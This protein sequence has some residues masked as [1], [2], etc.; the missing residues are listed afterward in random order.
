MDWEEASRGVTTLRLAEIIGAAARMAPSYEDAAQAVLRVLRE[1]GCWF[2]R[3]SVDGPMG[4]T[5]QQMLP[6]E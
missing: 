5:V 2:C 6:L 3:L 4:E 1:R